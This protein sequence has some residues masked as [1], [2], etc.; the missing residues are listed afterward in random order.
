MSPGRG[1]GANIA[2]RDAALLREALVDVAANRATLAEAKTRYQTTML[3]Y[4]FEAVSA[5]LNNPFGPRR[6]LARPR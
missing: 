1:D 5:S 4:G 3:R 2:L 6:S